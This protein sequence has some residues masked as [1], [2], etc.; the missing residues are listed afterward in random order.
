MHALGSVALEELWSRIKS[1]VGIKVESSLN[2]AKESGEFD[3]EPGIYYGTE[4]P[5]DESHPVWIDPNGGEAFI[6]NKVSE[7]ENDAGYLTK[8]G[9]EITY[10]RYT[11][12]T[13]YKVGTFTDVTFDIYKE[14]YTPICVTA[15]TS[16]SGDVLVLGTGFFDSSGQGEID[17]TK[18]IVTYR[19][20]GSVEHAG[21]AKIEVAYIKVG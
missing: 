17:R 15:R 18:A 21:G 9:I 16:G 11:V 3:G 5:T 8:N 10:E 7:L 4:E 20:I 6:P 19:N 2:E 14:G 12:T 1:L 13:T